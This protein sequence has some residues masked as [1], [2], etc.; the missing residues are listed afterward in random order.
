MNIFVKKMN[1]F[2]FSSVKGGICM[3]IRRSMVL[4]LLSLTLCVAAMLGE[5][6]S[7]EEENVLPTVSDATVTETEA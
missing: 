5:R 7:R 3:K 1:I 2:I 6:E 4:C